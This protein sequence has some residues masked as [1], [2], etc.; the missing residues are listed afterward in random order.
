[1]I[2][3]L[4]VIG[5]LIF[6]V[7]FSNRIYKTV[8]IPKINL[9]K[10]ITKVLE[11]SKG[12]YSI[13]VKNLKTGESFS[14][15][16]HKPN[17][18]GS[19]Y[20][21]W[22]MATVFNQIQNGKLTEDEILSEDIQDLNYKFSIA[23]E[24]AELTE[25]KIT[26]TV[27]D[28]L[29]QMITISHNYAALLLTEKIK[30]SSVKSFLEKN[31]FLE[32]KVSDSAPISTPYNIA[33]FLEKLYKGKLANKKHTKSMLGLLKSQK[34]NDKLPKYLPKNVFIAHKTGEIDFLSHDAGIVYTEKGDYIIVVFSQSNYP[35][36]AN[37]R[38]A[39]ISKAV[40]E[41]FNNQK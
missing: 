10:T 9:E 24:E 12:K 27:H 11:G 15:N 37:E 20:K 39:Q 4:F 29:Q 7:L 31:G 16:S 19:L 30:L 28:A 1:M 40:Y 8:S 22:V 3:I 14:I 13:V 34:L 41:Y 5:F 38:I 33:L 25:G 17:K 32:S 36:G 2:R 26:L 23:S 18:T 6:L 21:L 35:K